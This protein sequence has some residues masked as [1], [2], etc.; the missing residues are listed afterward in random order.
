MKIKNFAVHM[1]VFGKI[2]ASEANKKIICE[3]MVKLSVLDYLA[4]V[5]PLGTK[6]IQRRLSDDEWTYKNLLA[7]QL[8]FKSEAIQKYIDAQFTEAL[9]S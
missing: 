9:N 5:L 6:T 1:T 3:G 7:I 2:L 8:H 4:I